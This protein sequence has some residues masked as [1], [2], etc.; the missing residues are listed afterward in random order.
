[1]SQHCTCPTTAHSSASSALLFPIRL[2][3]VCA[4]TPLQVGFIA[5]DRLVTQLTL[6]HTVAVC[7]QRTESLILPLYQ[8]L[9]IIVGESSDYSVAVSEAI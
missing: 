3:T 8:M 7:A 5:L 1:M 6:L 9:F 2:S 4:P